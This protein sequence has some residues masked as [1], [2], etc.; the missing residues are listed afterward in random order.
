MR[1]RST[2]RGNAKATCKGWAWRRS[3]QNTTHQNKITCTLSWVFRSSLLRYNYGEAACSVIAHRLRNTLW[4]RGQGQMHLYLI[5]SPAP[6]GF[7]TGIAHY[8]E[9]YEL[10]TESSQ[11]IGRGDEHD[12][13]LRTRSE[14]ETQLPLLHHHVSPMQAKGS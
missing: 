6:I 3:N 11:I 9:D 4:T 1:A 8:S 12:F 14:P 5:R 2:F 7:G 13:Q 10:V